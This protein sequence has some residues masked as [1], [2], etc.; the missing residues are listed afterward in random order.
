MYVLSIVTIYILLIAATCMSRNNV[1]LQIE[2]KNLLYRTYYH[3]LVQL[4]LYITSQC[5]NGQLESL[6]YTLTSKCHLYIVI[7]Y[8]WC[9]TN[10]KTWNLKTNS[11]L[12]VAEKWVEGTSN[13]RNVLRQLET[14]KCCTTSCKGRNYWVVLSLQRNIITRQVAAICQAFRGS[15]WIAMIEQETG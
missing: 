6:G 8:K 12:Q 11:V 3:I 5:Y 1:V 7:Y 15:N 10:L 2:H 9:T 4:L 13:F 14:W